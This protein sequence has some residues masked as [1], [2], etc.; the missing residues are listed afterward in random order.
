MPEMESQIVAAL[1]AGGY[2]P[3]KPKALARRLGITTEQYAFFRKTVR[4]LVKQ[5]R[6]EFG[7]NHTLR[8]IQ[9]HNSVTGIFRRTAS[10][11]GYV[12][13]HAVDGKTGPEILIREE[14]SKD[15]S[16][17]DVVAVRVA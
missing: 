16:T 11:D 13:P 1:S 15:A 5:G 9:P 17:G 3:I 12:R 7:R 8:P 4:D 2:S 6:I 10:G 14:H